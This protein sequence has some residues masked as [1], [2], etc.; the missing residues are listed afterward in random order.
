MI[1]TLNPTTQTLQPNVGLP[2][3]TAEE[4]SRIYGGEKHVELVKGR[5][6]K[7]KLMPQAR[8]GKS[9][10]KLARYLDEFAEE[11]DLG[12]VMSN[13]TFV[14]VNTIPESIRAA[15]VLYFSYAR[16]P[17]GEIP[18][19]L[20][21]CQPEIAVEVKSPS[22][23]WPH[24]LEKV[25]EYLASDILVV[26]ILD[27]STKSAR[28]YRPSQTVQTISEDQELTFPDVLP[29]FAVRL[30]KLFMTLPKPS[31]AS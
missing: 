3:L 28:I 12:H 9:C 25:S 19:G 8:H 14:K 7:E 15:D 13:D 1:S 16:L 29:G 18:E 26:V 2:L 6:V 30:T 23:T 17:R 21:P 27:A 11:H 22:N 10:T 24:L 4:F 20:L 5:V 31:A